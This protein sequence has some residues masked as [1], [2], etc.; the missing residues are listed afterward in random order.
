MSVFKAI[1]K[2]KK[3]P[4]VDEPQ[5]TW[6]KIHHEDVLLCEYHT[7]SLQKVIVQR[8]WDLEFGPGPT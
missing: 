7:S 5:G 3:M 4:W 2:K 1:L 8:A 6:L